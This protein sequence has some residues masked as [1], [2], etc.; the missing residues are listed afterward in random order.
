MRDLSPLPWRI[1]NRTKHGV[2]IVSGK[3]GAHLGYIRSLDDARLFEAVPYVLE[4]LES[5][6]EH[7]TPNSAAGIAIRRAL[8]TATLDECLLADLSA[9]H[10]TEIMQSVTPLRFVTEHKR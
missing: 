10:K 8:Y 3:S 4:T 6:L 1:A 5:L 7:H 9:K 2:Q